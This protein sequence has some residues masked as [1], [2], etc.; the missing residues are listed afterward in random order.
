MD[1]H[2]S[3]SE[4]MITIYKTRIKQLRDA[5]GRQRQTAEQCHT[6]ARQSRVVTDRIVY[7]E[8]ARRALEDAKR[9]DGRADEWSRLSA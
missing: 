2:D 4:I 5:A 9:F 8:F 6:L 3:S 1:N 7:E